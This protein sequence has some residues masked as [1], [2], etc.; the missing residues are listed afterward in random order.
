[1]DKSPTSTSSCLYSGCFKNARR[2]GL[3]QGVDCPPLQ[4]VRS[5]RASVENFGR[6]GCPRST[7]TALEHPKPKTYALAS[8]EIQFIGCKRNIAWK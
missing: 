5:D 7:N 8:N 6:L 4:P 1:M 2:G 3:R